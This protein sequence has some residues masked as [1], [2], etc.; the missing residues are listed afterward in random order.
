MFLLVP[1]IYLIWDIV[2]WKIKPK[3]SYRKFNVMWIIQ[4][5]KKIK[6]RWSDSQYK[7]LWKT[8]QCVILQN[9]LSHFMSL[10]CLEVNASTILFSCTYIWPYLSK[11]VEFSHNLCHKLSSRFDKSIY[12]FSFAANILMVHEYFLMYIKKRYRRTNSKI[13]IISYE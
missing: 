10:F 6:E 8:F 2:L 5:L 7:G 13:N 12:I 4:Y 9:A 3:F 11:I 1:C